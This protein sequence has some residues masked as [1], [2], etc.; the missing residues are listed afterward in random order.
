[1]TPTALDQAGR[2]LNLKTPLADNELV[3]TGFRGHEEMSR[4]FKYDLDFLSINK[5]VDAVKLVGKPIGFSVNTDDGRR[6]FHGVVS[7][8]YAGDVDDFGFRLYR[9]EVVPWLW[10]LQHT[11]DCR[12][13]QK[14]TAPQI[15][16]KIFTDLGFQD[17]KP[18]LSGSFVKREYC[19]Q[20]RETDFNFVSRL[21]E[22]EGI[23]YYFRHEEQKHVLHYGD[24][25]SAYDDCQE[26]E[27][28][29]SREA[30][31]HDIGGQLT[32]WEHRYEFRAGKWAQTDYNFET[33]T[34]S[35][36]TN[37]QSAL[38]TPD[39]KNFE[40]Y[41]YPGLYGKPAE[42]KPLT[43]IRMGEEEFEYDVVHA[44]ST[45]TSFAPGGR[46]KVSEHRIDAEAG[47]KYV[48]TSIRHSACE[49]AAY[50][51]GMKP[52]QDYSNSISCIPDSVILRPSR[53]T[54]KPV[55]QGL[56]TAVVVGPKGEEI[57]CDKYGRIKVQFHWDRV[58]KKDENSSCWIRTAHNIAGKQWGFQAVPRI[59]QEVVVDFLEGDPDRPLV[60][61]SVYNAG[62]MPHYELP[63]L[64]SRSYIKTNS[65]KGGDGYNELMFEDKKDA[66]QVFIHA[67][68]DMDT[69]VR[70][71]SKSRIYGNRHQIIGWEKD[72]KKGGDQQ[73]MVWQNKHLN[74]KGNQVEKIE[75]NFQLAIGFGEGEG[76][77]VDIK[78]MKNQRV[79]IA[80]DSS[81]KIGGNL[82]EQ[83]GGTVSMTVGGDSHDTVG[84]NIA[85]QAGKNIHIQGGMNVVIEAAMGI[86][87]KGPGGFITID[88]K[89]VA[90]Q[91][92]MV[93][94][95]SGGAALSG[96]GAKSEE[97]DEAQEAK[98]T[99]PAQAFDSKT[100][101][102]SAP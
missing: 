2:F 52:T 14:M 42:G 93:L 30:G 32:S 88:A 81:T 27:V 70:N 102:K 22:E 45:C 67:Q 73:E 19:V 17:F 23:F 28:G 60:I 68:K 78:V 18:N 39:S 43:D 44:T 58:G 24:A 98:P 75:G 95:N 61:G 5:N 36:M 94:I 100:G 89:G 64:N 40:Y 90:I 11:S 101:M 56:Q 82:K 47:K 53:I 46:F 13:F 50:T 62:Q 66:E 16:E 85:V 29:Y 55:V 87:I 6:Y 99:M 97:P 9:A 12:I 15:I 96:S 10:F 79:D 74:V 83:V 8:F 54:P 26:N 57:Y 4:L 65:T 76:G 51:P 91:G 37:S 63:S 71:D 92:T 25:A 84:A 69:R 48:I 72:G 3:L 7:R 1:M 80:A 35:L 38:P 77:D 59:G 33:P 41:D 86:T 31:Y 49:V 34:T 21:M 20:Y